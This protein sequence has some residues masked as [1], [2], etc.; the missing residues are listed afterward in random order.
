MLHY[1]RGTLT[2][3]NASV[4]TYSK[5]PDAFICIRTEIPDNSELE[6]VLTSN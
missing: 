5:H 6:H 1:T 3:F 4:G 2:I